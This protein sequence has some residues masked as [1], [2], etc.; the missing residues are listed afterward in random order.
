MMF[1]G[2]SAFPL[3]P[4]DADG[5]VQPD[6]LAGLV[7]RLVAADVDS[8]GLLGSTG[9]YAYLSRAQR[10]RATAAAVEAAAGRLP[11]IVGVGAIRTDAAISLARD[12]ARAGA[13]G[14]LLAPVSYTP[15]TQ[16]EALAHYRATAAAT[17]L[18]LVIYNNPGTTHFT[19]AENTLAAL[20]NEPQI[21]AV[22]MPLP[23]DRSLSADIAALRPQLPTDFALGYS[24]DWGCAEALLEGADSWFTAVGGI[25][26]E[27]CVA[28]TRAAQAGDTARVTR[29]NAQLAPLWA[30]CQT[31]GSLRVIQCIAQEMGLVTTELPRPLL[32]LS[33]TDKTAVRA[34]LATLT[35]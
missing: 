12:A 29:L 14:L 9:T 21:V 15:L 32:P 1:T 10:Q 28:I 33:D 5:T 6:Q 18:P 7:D 35:D 19:F 20:A 31:H 11:L 13:D 25:L 8:I 2:L 24:G 30:L 27:P 22:K 16:A 34:A 4:A 26:P 23:A 17:D 3:T